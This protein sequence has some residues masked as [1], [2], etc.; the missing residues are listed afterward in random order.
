MKFS[1]KLRNPGFAVVLWLYGAIVVCVPAV[2]LA[3]EVLQGQDEEEYRWQV[4]TGMQV[5]HQNPDLRYDPVNTSKVRAWNSNHDIPLTSF[6]FF[7]LQRKLGNSS[8][9]EFLYSSDGMGGD[10]YG[11]APE[12]MSVCI[13][14]LFRR[15][16][17]D[18]T[19]YPVYRFPLEIDVRTYK[20]T[21]SRTLWEPEPVSIG[22][23][24]SVHAL[25]LSMSA[26][27][28]PLFESLIGYDRLDYL[29]LAP[30]LGV[31]AEYRPKGPV[32]YRVSSGWMSVPL[33]DIEGKLIEVNA[34]AE[35]RLTDRFFFGVGYRFSD[36]NVHLHNKKYNLKG[37]YEVHGYQ[38]YTGFNF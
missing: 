16:C 19:I 33:G 18:I 4:R 24:V 15:T 34:Q 20:L 13:P 36:T 10:L 8:S 9:I 26:N 28:S 6:S 14:F 1:G 3:D 5:V 2:T 29:V 21:F 37:S 25:Q 23:S 38:L 32:T 7:S 31:F 12:K 27:L 35:Y 11:S 22:A 30:S 17:N